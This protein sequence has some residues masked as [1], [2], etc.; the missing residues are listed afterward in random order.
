MALKGAPA[1]GCVEVSSD[2]PREDVARH[3]HTV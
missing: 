3:D 2:G 1:T